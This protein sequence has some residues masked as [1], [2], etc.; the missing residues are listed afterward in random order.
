M[1]IQLSARISSIKPS[2][3]MV[4]S[5]TARR[6]KAEGKDVV[7]LGVGEPDF[8]TPDHILEAAHRAMLAGETRYTA[9]DGTPALKAAIAAKLKR[10]NALEFEPD[11]IIVSNGA[12]QVIFDALIVRRQRRWHRFEVVI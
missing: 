7:D 11:E 12:K 5:Q 6:L 10:E 3:S 1:S 8:P 4:V 9:T 2:A